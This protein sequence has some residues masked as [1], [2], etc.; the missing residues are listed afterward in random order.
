MY[1]CPREML[2]L[3]SRLVRVDENNLLWHIRNAKVEIVNFMGSIQESSLLL[4]ENLAAQMGQVC[5]DN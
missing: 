3:Q 5:G 2:T 1:L 4:Q